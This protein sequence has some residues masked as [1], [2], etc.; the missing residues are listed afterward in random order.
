MAARGRA[1]NGNNHYSRVE[2]QRLARGAM[3]GT[4]KLTEEQVAT[5]K[6]EIAL[7]TQ[8]YVTGAPKRGTNARLAEHFG[9]TREM[10]FQIAHGIQW[11]HVEPAV[12]TES[13][14]SGKVFKGA[15]NAKHAPEHIAAIK[16]ALLDGVKGSVLAKQYGVSQSNISAIKHGLLW[17]EIEPAPPR[18]HTSELAPAQA[19]M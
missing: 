15:S 4:S 19:A 3:V 11:A 18:D 14:L 8:A 10:I 6:G 13:I 1:P 12:I 9:V 2:P 7:A 17:P 5:I 16:R